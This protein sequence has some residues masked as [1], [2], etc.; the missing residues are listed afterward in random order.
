M[1]LTGACCGAR[2]GRGVAGLG[3]ISRRSCG[4]WQQDGEDDDI[5]GV[6]WPKLMAQIDEVDDEDSR[7]HVG[8]AAR[9]RWPRRRT[10]SLRL[11]LGSCAGRRKK[12]R[13]KAP[14]GNGG[15]RHRD[16]S[17]HRIRKR[18]SKQGGGVTWACSP[19][20]RAACLA[21]GRRRTCPWWSGP[22]SSQAGPGKLGWGGFFSFF[23]CSVNLFC[24][25]K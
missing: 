14:G 12:T 1:K 4:G 10:G 22:A 11:R 17:R 25:V 5:S 9:L 13:E 18:G 16:V 8:T 21:P 2:Q 24:P 7:G 23:F 15:G 6:P 20:R 19:R 3:E